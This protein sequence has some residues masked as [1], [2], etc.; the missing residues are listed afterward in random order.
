MPRPSRSC[1]FAILAVVL[2]LPGCLPGKRVDPGDLEIR[3][4]LRDPVVAIVGGQPHT[5]PGCSTVQ[6]PDVDLRGIRITTPTGLDLMR[7]DSPTGVPI[8][9]R[10]FIVIDTGFTDLRTGPRGVRPGP[11][12][13]CNLTLLDLLQPGG[14]DGPA[15]G[16]LGG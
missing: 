12:M 13:D 11:G 3:N 8:G 15:G 10:R 16:P 7:R 1:W 4:F 9:P 14:P 2:V 5:I 6:F